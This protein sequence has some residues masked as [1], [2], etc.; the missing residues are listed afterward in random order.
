MDALFI[1]HNYLFDDG[2]VVAAVV[3]VVQIR[4][5]HSVRSERGQQ[6]AESG[7]SMVKI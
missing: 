4:S 5:I 3:V 7:G 6:P 2:V 1:I